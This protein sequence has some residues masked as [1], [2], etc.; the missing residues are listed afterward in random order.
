MEVTEENQ[1]PENECEQVDRQ[2]EEDEEEVFGTFGSVH[3]MLGRGA[4]FRRAA[5]RTDTRSRHLDMGDHVVVYPEHHQGLCS[6]DKAY[7]QEDTNVDEEAQTAG[8]Y[9]AIGDTPM[10]QSQTDWRPLADAAANKPNLMYTSGTGATP[11]QQSQTDWRS[12]ADAAANKPNPMYNTRTGARNGQHHQTDTTS[13]ADASANVPN[14][15]HTALTGATPMQQSQ[16]DWRSLADAAAKIPNPM[17]NTRTGATH[18]QHHQI[19]TTSQADASANV[20]NQRHTALTGA[21]PMQQP[22]TDWRSLADAAAKIPNPMYNTRTGATPMQQPQTDWRSL[23]DAAAKIPNPMYNT[24]TGATPMQ[25]SQTDWRSL[26][27]AAAKIPNPMYNTGTGATPMQQSQ[28]DWRSLAD[29]AAKIPNPMYNTRTGARNGQQ[30]SQADASANVPNQR[31][32][33]ITDR[34]I[35]M[36][37]MV[38]SSTFFWV[39]PG[40]G[41]LVIAAVAIAAI[42]A[43]L[44]IS[45]GKVTQDTGDPDIDVIL[46][47]SAFPSWW[48]TFDNSSAFHEST[49]PSFTSTPLK[50]IDECIKRPCGYGRCVNYPGGYRCTC[51]RGWTGQNCRQDINECTRN[52]CQHGTCVNTY[53]GYHCNCQQGWTG[54]NC[55]QDISECARNPCQHGTCV[56]TYGGYHCN[57]QQGWTGTNCHQAHR[58]CQSGWSEYNNHCYKLFKDK[59]NWDTANGRCKQHGANLASV[60]SA[61]EN[62]FIARLI[63]DAPRVHEGLVWFGLRRNGQWKWTDGSPFSYKNWDPGLRRAPAMYNCASMHCKDSDSVWGW[64]PKAKKGHW[65]Y[66]QM[67]SLQIPYV[68]KT[69]K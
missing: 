12:L 2:Y 32:I 49:L 29:A 38:R 40:C 24:G 3:I 10:Q 31:H 18:G 56:N 58:R 23:A 42:V 67:C 19:D 17:Y 45:R 36:W 7:R 14:Q 1:S 66:I 9:N 65:T 16:T 61:G 41:L 60:G 62:N 6:D 33:A 39:A 44:P 15:R 37:R 25:Q 22:Q 13:Q 30:T 59:V 20:P 34:A 50:D 53:G 35:E 51:S 27:D 5:P 64:A 28:T 21:T 43:S 55:Q 48:T 68:C 46:N 4:K 26:A 69:L 8:V 11:M 52:P 63:S 54:T 57:C 47:V